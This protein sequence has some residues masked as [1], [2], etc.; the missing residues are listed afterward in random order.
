M[1]SFS[2]DVCCSVSA[3]L[4]ENCVFKVHLCCSL[5]QSL[6][7]FHGRVIFHCA[8][9]PHAVYP[10]I[11]Y[12]S[13]DPSIY[14]PSIHPSIHQSSTHPAIHPPI[15]PSIH[16]P[17]SQPSMDTCITSQ[18]PLSIK[19]LWAWPCKNV[20]QTFLPILQGKYPE[21]RLLVT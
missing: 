18:M 8:Y 14:Q 2:I 4:T 6:T 7:P 20:L 21:L 3:S 5:C 1:E 10:P 13:R 9:R 19:P 15:H 17:P 11:H 12:P 16:P